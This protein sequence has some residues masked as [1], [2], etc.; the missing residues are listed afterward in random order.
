M[1]NEEKRYIREKEE[2]GEVLVIRPKEP[3]SIS[4]IEKNPDEIERVYKLGRA[5]A[6]EFL[7]NHTI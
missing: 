2:R 3:L 4:P 1:Y 5:A 7:V 6:E